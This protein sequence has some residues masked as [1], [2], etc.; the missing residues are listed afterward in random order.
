MLQSNRYSPAESW[1]SF[2]EAFRIFYCMAMAF[3]CFYRIGMHASNP[4]VSLA[5]SAQGDT[6]GWLAGSVLRADDLIS[7]IGERWE[8]ERD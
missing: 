6:F 5:C 2:Y 4:S 8:V 7:P 1:Q 3:I